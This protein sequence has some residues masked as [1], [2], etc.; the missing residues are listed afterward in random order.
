MYSLSDLPGRHSGKGMASWA[1]N[2]VACKPGRKHSQVCVTAPE[3]VEAGSI[4]I[5]VVPDVPDPQVSC[6]P[7]SDVPEYCCIPEVL[8]EIIV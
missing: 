5:V 8:R 7:D 4:P 1:A 3:A 2:A 6:L